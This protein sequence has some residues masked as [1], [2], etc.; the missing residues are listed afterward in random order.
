M[1]M[2]KV[3]NNTE[4]KNAIT[5]KLLSHHMCM[6]NAQT[7]NALADAMIMASGNANASGIPNDFAEAEVTTVRMVKKIKAKKT[8]N[9]SLV[10]TG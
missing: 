7:R 8:P 10:E 4:D 9:N 6:K 1:L 2:N 3:T 5:L